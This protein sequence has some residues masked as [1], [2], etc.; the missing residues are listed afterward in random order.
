VYVPD[1]PDRCRPACPAA[2]V[3]PARAAPAL[4][5]APGEPPCQ[6]AGP[7]YSKQKLQLEITPVLQRIPV[8]TYEDEGRVVDPD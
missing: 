4:A 3:G 1:R 5:D 2:A 7:T 8:Q 6:L